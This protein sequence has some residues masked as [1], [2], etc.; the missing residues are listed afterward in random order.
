MSEAN[1]DLYKANPVKIICRD[2]INYAFN[3]QCTK[4]IIT[5]VY[6][7]RKLHVW[8]MIYYDVGMYLRNPYLYK[9]NQMLETITYETF[10]ESMKEESYKHILIKDLLESYSLPYNPLKHLVASVLSQHS[11]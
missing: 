9:I 6:E 11:K 4:D 5:I 3:D 10:M 7:Y 8:Y 2:G 1:F